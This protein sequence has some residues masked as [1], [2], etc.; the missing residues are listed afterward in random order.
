M[1]ML[2]F[3]YIGYWSFMIIVCQRRAL[4]VLDKDLGRFR[5]RRIGRMMHGAGCER[6]GCEAEAKSMAQ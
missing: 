3:D 4:V 2:G 5:L 6:R 1:V